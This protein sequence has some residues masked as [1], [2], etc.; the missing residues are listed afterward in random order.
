M[1]FILKL[2]AI[3]AKTPLRF[4]QQT[5]YLAPKS[6]KIIHSDNWLRQSNKSSCE[7]FSMRTFVASLLKLVAF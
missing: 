7:L 2:L 1:G 6:E 5:S 4:Q 3:L